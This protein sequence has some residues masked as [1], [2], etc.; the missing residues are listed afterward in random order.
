[1]PDEVEP[2]PMEVANGP[3]RMRP[4]TEGDY[5]TRPG[6]QVIAAA[7]WGANPVGVLDRPI[8][9]MSAWV[10]AHIAL[11][12]LEDAEFTVEPPDGFELP[13]YIKNRG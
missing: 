7:F 10:L 1:M 8:G 3:Q 9:D 6:A 5:Y 2:H 13:D 4:R 11:D 12:A